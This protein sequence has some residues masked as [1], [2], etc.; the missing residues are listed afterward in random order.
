[1]NISGEHN[2]E[3]K[4]TT[5]GPTPS[6]KPNG[7]PLVPRLSIGQ[8]KK[9]AIACQALGC[10]RKFTSELRPHSCKRCWYAL[11]STVHELLTHDVAVLQAK[12]SP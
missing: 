10:G 1:M 3:G 7:S 12:F 9:D 5:K 2:A 4:E 8:I 6:L 11:W